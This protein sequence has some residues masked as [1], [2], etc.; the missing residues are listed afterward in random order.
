VIGFSYT[1]A[2]PNPT[3]GI[4]TIDPFVWDRGRM[5]D[6][7]SLGGTVGRPFHINKRGQIVGSSN[8]AGDLAGHPF[9]W[10][11]GVL[12]DLGTLG[13]DNGEQENINDAGD[14]VGKADLPGSQIHDG[15]LWHRGVM[16]DL[17]TLTG[18][19]CSRAN[20]VNAQR[21][22]VG[23]VS[24][25]EFAHHA[26][27]WER[28]GSLVDLNSLIPPNSSLELTNAWDINDRGEIAGI[29]VPAGCQPDD[30]ET[31]GHAYLLVPDGDCD[32]DCENRVAQSQAKAELGRQNSAAISHPTE[33][34][35]IPAVRA[36]SMMRQRLHLPGQNTLPRD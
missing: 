23:N 30:A 14:V 16:T 35:V 29:G 22:V 18:Y 24:F 11:R 31:C 9:L 10:D 5:V 32:D 20:S 7:G 34:T 3:T 25:C 27:L 15:F 19:P 28:E 4:P 13:G 33:P 26:V 21:Q 12:T 8:L 36:R 17:G 2:I 6:L 1:N